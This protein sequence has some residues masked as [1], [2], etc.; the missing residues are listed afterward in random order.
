MSTTKEF[1]RNVFFHFRE[2]EIP[3]ESMM[4][5]TRAMFIETRNISKKLLVE[6]VF[7]GLCQSPEM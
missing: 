6:E 2:R 1:I 7:G 4:I 3:S 5:E